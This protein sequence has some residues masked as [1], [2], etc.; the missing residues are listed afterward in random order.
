MENIDNSK[1]LNIR[2]INFVNVFILKISMI[3]NI[4]IKE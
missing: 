1:K 3:N 4:K 2:Y